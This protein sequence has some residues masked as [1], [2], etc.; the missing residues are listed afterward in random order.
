MY[1]FESHIA[2]KK[3][4]CKKCRGVI[5]APGGPVRHDA[6]SAVEDAEM[7]EESVPVTALAVA[8]TRSPFPPPLPAPAPPTSPGDNGPTVLPRP[9]WRDPVKLSL[10]AASFT[11]FWVLIFFLCV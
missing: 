2:G 11:A 5:V 6:G 8:P 7:F 10:A 3:M 1:R 9:L 4:Q